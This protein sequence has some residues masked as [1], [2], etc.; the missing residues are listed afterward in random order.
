MYG[1]VI[2]VRLNGSSGL[3]VT[4]SDITSYCT[5]FYRDVIPVGKTSCSAFNI[6]TAYIAVYFAGFNQNLIPKSIST[7]LISRSKNMTFIALTIILLYFGIRNSYRV[8]VRPWSFSGAREHRGHRASTYYPASNFTT[9][10]D[11]V[12]IR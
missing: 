11:N 1:D 5:V 3:I 9:I 6:T 8:I 10:N 12:I 4:A 7:P 2:I